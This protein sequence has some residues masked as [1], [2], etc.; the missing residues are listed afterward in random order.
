MSIGSLFASWINVLLTAV[1]GRGWG[2]GRV[3]GGFLGRHTLD[4]TKLISG[5]WEEGLYLLRLD[6]EL[7]VKDSLLIST[8][9]TEY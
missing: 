5:F 9:T 1:P 4:F 8:P 7:R 2:G 3:E 6:L